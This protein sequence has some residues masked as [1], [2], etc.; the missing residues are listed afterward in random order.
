MVCTFPFQNL[1]FHFVM[2]YHMT[3]G[4]VIVAYVIH[5]DVR[6]HFID[7]YFG[8]LGNVNDF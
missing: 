3:R 5:V 1:T 8:L 2:D 7:I 6:R 4:Y